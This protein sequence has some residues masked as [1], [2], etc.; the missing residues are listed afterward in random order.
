[1]IVSQSVSVGWIGV[2]L[3]IVAFLIMVVIASLIAG[4]IIYWLSLPEPPM[5]SE[6]PKRQE[7]ELA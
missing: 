7:D 3:P 1:M 6:K 5:S 4:V 2:G